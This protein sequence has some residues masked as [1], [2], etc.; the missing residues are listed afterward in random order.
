MLSQLKKK[1]VLFSRDCVMLAASTAGALGS[2]NGKK[3]TPHTPQHIFAQQ[4][5]EARESGGP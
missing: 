5:R 4:A 1:R 2:A 3:Q